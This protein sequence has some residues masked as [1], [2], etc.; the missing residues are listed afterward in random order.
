MGYVPVTIEQDIEGTN[1]AIVTRGWAAPEGGV[2][3]VDR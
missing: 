2:Q 1:M 3:G